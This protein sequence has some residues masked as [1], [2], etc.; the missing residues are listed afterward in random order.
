MLVFRQG[1]YLAVLGYQQKGIQAAIE[2]LAD[3]KF[4][5]EKWIA[6]RIKLTDLVEKGI[7]ALV[8]DRRKHVEILVDLSV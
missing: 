2:A 3:G 6:I 7:R 1:K 5:P 8:E 4:K